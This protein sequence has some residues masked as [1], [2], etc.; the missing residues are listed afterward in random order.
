M[1]RRVDNRSAID[2]TKVGV[3][4]NLGEMQKDEVRMPNRRLRLPEIRQGTHALPLFVG[5]FLASVPLAFRFSGFLHRCSTRC[6]G[7]IPWRLG[8]H[9]VLMRALFA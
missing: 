6:H 8:G 7:D 9:M 4:E 5:V 1:A 2:G 3:R